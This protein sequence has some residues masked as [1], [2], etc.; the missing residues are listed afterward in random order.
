MTLGTYLVHNKIIKEDGFTKFLDD[1]GLEWCKNS[2]SWI[3]QR[4]MEQYGIINVGEIF[5]NWEKGK[6]KKRV[7]RGYGVESPLLDNPRRKPIPEDLPEEVK[8]WLNGFLT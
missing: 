8:T 3:A 5:D 2:K 1:K 6:N 7:L 4:L